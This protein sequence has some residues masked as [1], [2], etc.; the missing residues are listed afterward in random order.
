[1]NAI[2]FRVLIHDGAE[3]S[4]KMCYELL[5]TIPARVECIMFRNYYCAFLKIEAIFS[6]DPEWKTIQ[7]K[8]SLM[9]DPHFENDAQDWHRIPMKDD[10]LVTKLR[11]TAYQPSP[12]WKKFKID[13]VRLFHRLHKQSTPPPRAETPQ[14]RNAAQTSGTNGKSL[15][16]LCRNANAFLEQATGNA[17]FSNRQKQEAFVESASVKTQLEFTIKS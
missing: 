6:V 10:R 15:A 7:Q 14:T 3:Q 2:D 13:Q 9:T 17:R 16:D 11:L 5:L 8:Y 1:M 12:C 4:R